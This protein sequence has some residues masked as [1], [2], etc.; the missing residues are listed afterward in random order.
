VN[1]KKKSQLLI[2]FHVIWL[3]NLKFVEHPKIKK[4]HF[5]ALWTMTPGATTPLRPATILSFR[6]AMIWDVKKCSLVQ[7]YNVSEESSNTFLPLYHVTRRHIQNST[8]VVPLLGYNFFAA[9]D[10]AE[11]P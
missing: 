6:M 4:I 1:L 10:T 11:Q 5:A 3:N 8:I 9:N 7:A 2:K